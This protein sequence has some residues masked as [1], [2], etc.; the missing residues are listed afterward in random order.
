VPVVAQGVVPTTDS[1]QAA[2]AP[3]T[4]GAQATPPR[5]NG[6]AYTRETFSYPESLDRRDPF[7]PLSAGD[8]IGP[9]FADLELNGV[10]FAPNIGSVAVLTDQATLKRYR[11]REGEWLGDARIDQIR[12][13]EVVFTV[14][15]FGISR[16]EVLRV[17]KDDGE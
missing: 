7:A 6:G 4:S 9:R 12:A 16:T 2:P 10:I 3:D 17:S 14:A 1:A 13:D 8:E 15:G 5:E 11:A